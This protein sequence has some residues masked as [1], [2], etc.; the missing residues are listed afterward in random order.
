MP[1][2]IGQQQARA[3]RVAS[4]AVAVSRS[5]VT[6]VVVLL[7]VGNWVIRGVQGVPSPSLCKWFLRRSLQAFPL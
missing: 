4:L 5:V 7:S 3:H 6:V 1:V 2:P